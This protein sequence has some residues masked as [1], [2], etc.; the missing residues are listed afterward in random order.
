M[1]KHGKLELTPRLALLADWV[2]PGAALAD[3]GTDHGF[4]P[5][6][7]VLRGRVTRAIASDLRPGPLSRARK[8]AAEQGAEGIDFRLCRGLSGIAPQEAD[9]VVIAGMGGENIASILAA[10]PWSADGR[11]TL[12][13]QPMTRA[14]VLRGFLA[15]SGYCV[16][17]EALVLDRG[18]LYPVLE[19]RGGTMALSL[20]QRYGGAALVR[21]PLEDRYLIEQ[22]LRFQ[23]A[24]AGRNRSRGEPAASGETERLR[25][26]L[27]ALMAMREE[28]R[29]ANSPGN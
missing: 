4:L 17:R 26:I 8:T 7:L 22:I 6:W 5:V 24:V 19:A 14:E 29:H 23:T 12:L 27:T 20:G 9:T 3:V 18:T 2:R 13:L 16:T 11:H 28:W 15:E 10:A 1:E 21:D 25:D